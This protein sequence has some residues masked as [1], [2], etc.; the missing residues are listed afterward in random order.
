MGLP[1]RGSHSLTPALGFGIPA[2]NPWLPLK[3]EQIQ[4]PE[5][6]GQ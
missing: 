6:K 5:S 3:T 4:K 2:G 1:G